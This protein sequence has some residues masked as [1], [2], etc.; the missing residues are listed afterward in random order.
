MK[1][2]PLGHIIG[3]FPYRLALAGGWYDQ[4]FISKHDPDPPGSM[5]VVQIEPNFPAMERSGLATSTRNTAAILWHGIL[6]RRPK[7][8]LMKEL[9]EAENRGKS[10]P[11]GSQ[12]MA[13]LI[14]PGINKLAYH[15]AING[16]K[17]PTSITSIEHVDR[18]RWLEK[19]LHILPIAPRPL[20]YNPLS[21]KNL[22]P[23]MI[24]R[25]GRT[26]KECF[27]AIW[28]MDSRALG[29]S[30]NDCMLCWESI[31]PCTVKHR[32]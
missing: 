3:T 17:F 14:Y 22:D 6:P 24:S 25:L 2:H 15:Y 5:V 21:K 12:D 4:P 19:V 32:A 13:G 7:E 23:Q 30:F 31:L 9:Y 1:K 8:T 29:S 28:N 20:G 27:E 10:A 11:S 26:G 16:G 18:F